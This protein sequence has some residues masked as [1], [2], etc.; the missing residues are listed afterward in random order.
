MKRAAALGLVFV[1]G[2]LGVLNPSQAAALGALTPTPSPGVPAPGL[3]GLVKDEAAPEG[4]IGPDFF[5]PSINPLTGLQVSDLALLE[6]RPM[7][8]K[9]TNH[10]RSVRPQSGLSRADVIYEYYIERGITRFIGI[11]YGQDAEKVGPVRSGRFFDEHIFRMYDAIF[12]FDSADDKVMEYFLTLGPQIYLRFA[13]EGGIDGRRTCIEGAS[14]PLCRDPQVLDYNDLFA[15]TRALGPAILRR[16]TYNSAPDLTG[17]RFSESPPEGGAQADE[18]SFRYSL[19]IYGKWEYLAELGH[20]L[21]YQE[22]IGSADSGEESYAPLS[23]AL[24]GEQLSA[25]NV[26][27]LFV[28]HNYYIKSPTTEIIQIDLIGNGE[29]WV[30]RNGFGYPA[31]WERPADGGVLQILTLQGEPFALKAGQTWY[32]V[33]SLESSAL[34]QGSQWRFNFSPPPVPAEPIYPPTPTALPEG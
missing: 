2:A 30:F 16:G 25:D 14:Y 27:V 7:A 19:L 4:A 32:Q 12:A 23:D 15:D 3:D 24:T 13:I 26:V 22:T 20:Y 34:Q 28:P 18:L 8:I 10:P 33:L 31:T 1:L 21:R 17:M 11:F 29:A 9:V 5:F 6:R